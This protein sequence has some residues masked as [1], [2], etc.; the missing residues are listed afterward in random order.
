[1]IE[2]SLNAQTERIQALLFP[3]N[4]FGLLAFGNIE[5]AP[6]EHKHFAG[7]VADNRQLILYPELMSIT[8]A[9]TVFIGGSVVVLYPRKRFQDQA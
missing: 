5:P 4:C 6:H 7:S 8:V 1:M 3:Q 2:G 9:D